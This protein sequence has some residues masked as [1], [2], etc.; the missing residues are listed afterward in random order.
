M[1]D[2]TKMEVQIGAETSGIKTGTAD[3]TVAVQSMAQSMQ[4][5]AKDLTVAMQSQTKSMTEGFQKISQ[6]AQ[7][8]AN[9]TQHSITDM[10]AGFASGSTTFS[11]LLSGWLGPIAG[12]VAG[13]GSLV[14]AFKESVSNMDEWTRSS[15]QLARGL[16]MTTRDASILKVSMEELAAANLTGEVSTQMLLRAYQM[17]I[18]KF[19]QGSPEIEKWGVTWKGTGMATFMDMVEKYQDL[20]SATDKAQM[21]S[22]FFGTRLGLTLMPILQNLSKE[23]LA[24][25]AKKAEELRLIV[26]QQLVDAARDS[27]VATLHLHESWQK[28]NSTMSKDAYPIWTK[29]K[30][31]MT[32]LVSSIELTYRQVEMLTALIRIS[33]VTFI[34]W[35]GSGI[36]AAIQSLG[37]LITDA[38]SAE[39]GI[40]ALNNAMKN[41]PSNF[42]EMGRGATQGQVTNPNLTPMPA[43][44]QPGP[45]PTKLGKGG[46]GGG[47]GDDRLTQWKSELDQ[48]IASQKIFQDQSAELTRDFYVKKAATGQVATKEETDKLQAQEK[49]A[50]VARL[51]AEKAFW[52]TKLEAAGEGSKLYDQVNKIILN[53]DQQ[54]NKARLTSETDLAKAK[55]AA[56]QE[57]IKTQED[58]L[59]QTIALDKIDLETKKANLDYEVKAGTKSKLEELQEYKA[60]LAQEQALDRQAAQQK[61]TLLAGDVKAQRQADAELTLLKK[62]QQLDMQKIDQQ[63]SLESQ[64][65]MKQAWTGI[66]SAF[67]SAIDSMTQAGANFATIMGQFG[68]SILK[69]FLSMIEGIVSKWVEGQL[70]MLI[71]GETTDKMSATSSVGASAAEAGAAAF[72]SA[73]ATLPWP[74]NMTVA[75]AA[76]M[77]AA[78]TAMG[79]LSYASAAGGWWEV[80]NVTTT[81]LH[82]QEMVLPAGPAAG[83]RSMIEGGG[84]GGNPVVV[85]LAPNINYRMT[86][87]EW[88]SQAD[89]MLKAINRALTR[90]GKQPLSP[91]FT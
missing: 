48:M 66:S 41:T 57:D 31:I 16:G 69:V 86:Q 11:G 10:I 1:A 79:F 30:E 54:T 64:T 21:R 53:L 18:Q 13:L 49:A 43:T 44:D 83:L 85:N 59:K 74:V 67:G 4:Q 28:L 71:V 70:A 63:I 76:G 82:P 38:G 33:T 50:Q 36:G 8:T 17:F 5:S 14:A 55:M 45:A 52:E 80:P 7:Q 26:G 39:A 42:R 22:D 35:A 84:G 68:Q 27:S 87:Q 15:L 32:E 56:H 25:A 58:V 91:S 34:E 65:Y 62:K 78:T 72:A 77:T 24:E 29:T 6:A 89:M 51:N 61:V 90:F 12:I 37:R 81:T 88:H 46:G 73:M 3:A 47:G 2:D 9:E 23:G 20:T 19:S 40:K 75:L 60:I